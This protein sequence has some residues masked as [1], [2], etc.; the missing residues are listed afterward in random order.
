MLVLTIQFIAKYA[1]DLF[2]IFFLVVDTQPTK[3]KKLIAFLQSDHS[4]DGLSFIIRKNFVNIHV[5]IHIL[6]KNGSWASIH[7]M[8]FSQKTVGKTSFIII[9]I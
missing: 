1:S 4:N 5:I 3:F 8:F 2:I 7:L 6:D 9:E